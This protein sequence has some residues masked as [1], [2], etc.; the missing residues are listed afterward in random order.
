MTLKTFPF[1]LAVP[2]LAGI[3]FVYYN[4]NV[5]D[6]RYSLSE[7]IPF[8]SQPDGKPPDGRAPDVVQQ[9]EIKNIGSLQADNV[10]VKIRGSIKGYFLKQA[11]RGACPQRNDRGSVV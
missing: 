4:R 7:R 2:I 5:P 1:Y 10:L 8:C 3:F 9:L 6:V 11:R